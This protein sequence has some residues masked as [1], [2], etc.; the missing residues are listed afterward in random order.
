MHVI[1][2]YIISNYLRTE[3]AQG[4]EGWKQRKTKEGKRVI[5]G[6]G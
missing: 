2:H 4:G 3:K 1:L 5:F 6:A